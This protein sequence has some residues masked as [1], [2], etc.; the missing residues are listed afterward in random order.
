MTFLNPS[1]FAT[2]VDSIAIY[3]EQLKEHK[4]NKTYNDSI[5]MVV[6]NY[7]NRLEKKERNQNKIN[8]IGIVIAAI[9]G[10]FIGRINS[11]LD[12]KK[13]NI[14]KKRI[15]SLQLISLLN[16]F[17]NNCNI[18]RKYLPDKDLVGVVIEYSSLKDIFTKVHLYLENPEDASNAFLQS[19]NYNEVKSYFNMQNFSNI[20]KNLIELQSITNKLNNVTEIGGLLELLEEIKADNTRS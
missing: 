18:I 5:D 17:N 19:S 14:E 15:Y 7:I 12:K 13:M 9:I 8:I 11:Y 6:D 1:T 10:F 2:E 3:I 20:D 16:D 4:V